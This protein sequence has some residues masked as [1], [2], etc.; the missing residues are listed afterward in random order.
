MNYK[1]LRCPKCKNQLKEE[2]MGKKCPYC[3]EWQY[4]HLATAYCEEV[5][6]YG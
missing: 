4:E 6:K 3:G 2:D 1:V 5:K